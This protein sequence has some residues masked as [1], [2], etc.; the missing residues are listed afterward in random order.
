MAYPL[1]SRFTSGKEVKS[2]HSH[3]LATILRNLYEVTYQWLHT[4]KVQMAN[5][6]KIPTQG[7]TSLSYVLRAFLRLL[8]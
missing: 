6:M 7:N 8:A 2:L 5:Q 3:Y 1:R 4:L